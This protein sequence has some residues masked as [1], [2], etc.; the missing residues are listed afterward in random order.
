MK[1]VEAALERRSLAE[2][3]A[4]P[5]VRDPVVSATLQLLAEI[6]PAGW[7]SNPLMFAFCN[8]NTVR[9]SIVHGPGT[10][11]A[12]GFAAYALLLAQGGEYAKAYDIGRMAIELARRFGNPAEESKVLLIFDTFVN[13]WRAPFA[14]PYRCIVSGF[15]GPWS[16]EIFNGQRS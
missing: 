12:A 2:I 1:E 9:L 7:F 16:P 4:L 6:I 15:N 10:T 8:L 3:V 11:S 14:R 13:H 5:E